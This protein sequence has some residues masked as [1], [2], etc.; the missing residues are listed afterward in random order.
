MAE[1][2]SL[3]S[4]RPRR[5]TAGNRME[6][7]LA[8]L[9][10]EEPKEVEEDIDFVVEKDEEDVFESDFA[11]TDEEAAQ[12]DVDEGDRD[13]REEERRERKTAR[14]RFEKATA[15][16]HERQRVTFNPQAMLSQP[17]SQVTQR[18]KRRVSLG[19]VVNAETGEVIE[20]GAGRV[21]AKR[22][23]QR[24]HTIMNTSATVNRIKDAEEKRAAIPKKTKM[25]TRLPTQDELIA[26]ALDTEEGN[27]IEHRDYLRLEEEKRA[28]ARVVKQAIEGPVLRWVSKKETI[29]VEHSFVY[30]SG[31]GG[32]TVGTQAYSI[33]FYAYMPL[34]AQ[35]AGAKTQAAGASASVTGP[36]QPQ[37]SAQ[38]PT[39]AQ[40]KTPPSSVL[41]SYPP[42]PT[43]PLIA[44]RIE[45]VCKNYVIHELSQSVPS[46]PPWKDTMSAMFGDHVQWDEVKVF[47]NKGRPLARPVRTCL[48][49]G[50]PAK[51]CDPRTNVP[52]ANVGAYEVL[53][54]VIGRGYVWSS[55]LGCY[56]GVS[57]TSRRDRR[58]GG[59]AEG[60]A[61]ASVGTSTGVVEGVGT[62][63]AEGVAGGEEDGNVEDEAEEL[64][65]RTVKRR[66]VEVIEG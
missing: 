41:F 20:G 15:A 45:D 8:E 31:A 37:A 56:V 35:N 57:E 13:V 55:A 34:V 40:T 64:E 19:V 23:S 3:V 10:L 49:T 33:P 26:R 66:R 14:A 44:H 21:G 5:S 22:K 16:A 65:D 1:E 32:G 48:I 12:E 39:F 47:T 6:L 63:V 9:A 36:P 29:Q 51:Y 53:T 27:I 54:K 58:P 61:S 42:V 62:G 24:R 7:A 30:T 43:T 11:S 17:R 60:G 46:K 38:P 25:A 50:Q 59:E 2:E 52:F 18:P 28:K 4:R